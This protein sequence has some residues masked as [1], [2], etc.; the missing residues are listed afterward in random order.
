MNS[1]QRR[2]KVRKQKREIR[3]IMEAIPKIFLIGHQ[4]QYKVDQ[5]AGMTELNKHLRE[6]EKIVVGQRLDDVLKN[7]KSS[8]NMTL[9]VPHGTQIADIIPEIEKQLDKHFKKR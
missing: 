5:R 6:G 7:L 9:N 8:F 3:L 2:K 4:A 1:R